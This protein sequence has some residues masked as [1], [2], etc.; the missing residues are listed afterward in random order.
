MKYESTKY[1]NI[2]ITPFKHTINKEIIINIGPHSHTHYS[3][4]MESAR[5][6]ALSLEK[7]RLERKN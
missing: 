4:R 5:Q 6:I 7:K 2:N 1:I 3:Q